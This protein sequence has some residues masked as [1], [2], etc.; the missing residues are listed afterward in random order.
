M[1]RGST[2]VFPNKQKDKRF[3]SMERII[4]KNSVK[5]WLIVNNFLSIQF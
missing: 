3:N 4:G 1:M 5:A 2:L